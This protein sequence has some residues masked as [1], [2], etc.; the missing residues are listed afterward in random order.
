MLYLQRTLRHYVHHFLCKFL[1][2]HPISKYRVY[3]IFFILLYKYKKYSYFYRSIKNSYL[4]ILKTLGISCLIYVWYKS[5]ARYQE[6][7]TL[8]ND[9]HINFSTILKSEQTVYIKSGLSKKVTF[10]RPKN[11]AKRVVELH[12]CYA[13]TSRYLCK[14][15]SFRGR[16]F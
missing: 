2:W 14:V 15:D 5:H 9:R 10:Y 16:T 7:S 1:V 8:S 11:E 12:Y 6:S 4:F 3:D 13:N